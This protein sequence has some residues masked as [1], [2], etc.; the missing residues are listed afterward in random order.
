MLSP[1]R[2]CSVFICKCLS[3]FVQLLVS[4]F[5][6]HLSLV[7]ELSHSLL[8][9]FQ[10][11]IFLGVYKGGQSV[12]SKCF[13]LTRVVV[14]HFIGYRS[15]FLSYIKDTNAMKTE[16]LLADLSKV[17]MGQ[18]SWSIITLI[19]NCCITEATNLIRRIKSHGI[20]MRI[21]VTKGPRKGRT[22]W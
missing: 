4:V 7:T 14:P 19:W 9:D 8:T 17:G 11:Q 12:F 5:P 15:L 2:W 10:P 6:C 13:L 3:Q 1:R 21:I 20:K 22:R 16:R 18:N